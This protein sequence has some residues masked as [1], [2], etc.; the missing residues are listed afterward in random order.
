[1]VRVRAF[2]LGLAEAW[3]AGRIS[4]ELHL[5]TGE[6]AVAVGVTAHLG[7]AD[8]LALDHRGTPPLVAAGIDLRPLAA[9]MLGLDEGL[10]RGRGGHMHL[11]A[12]RPFAVSSGIVGAAGPAAVGFALAARHAARRGVAVAFFGDGAVNQGALLES[13]NLAVAWRLPVVF[14]CKDNGWAVTTRSESVTGGE[15]LTRARGFGLEAHDVDGGDVAAVHEL[16]GPVIARAREGVAAFVH[17]TCPRLDGHFLGDKLVRVAKHLGGAEGREILESSM[18]GAVEP[19]APMVERITALLEQMRVLLR[20]RGDER[21]K[22]DDP[23]VRARRAAK[24]AGVDVD[25]L[26]AELAGEITAV[27][28]DL[29]PTRGG[30][31]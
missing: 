26:D 7:E 9:E 12:R 18:R 22:A 2:E 30:Q 24:R 17:A 20:A 25:A 16:M 28:E 3:R 8:A 31:S 21:G 4:G 19:G 14:V 11:F 29:T 1:M 6:E 13:F 27:F 10:C 23:L 15:L 5:G